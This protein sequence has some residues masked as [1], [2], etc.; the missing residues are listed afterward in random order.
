MM[1]LQGCMGL[2]AY[3]LPMYL[4][5]MRDGC[6]TPQQQSHVALHRRRQHTDQDQ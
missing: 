2:S 1:P 3:V 4:Q 6:V 5:G